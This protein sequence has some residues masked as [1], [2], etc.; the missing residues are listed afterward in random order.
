MAAT[1]DQ[2]RVVRNEGEHRY[3]LWAGE[4]LA[5]FA[6]FRNG[7]EWIKIFHAE[8]APAYEGHGLGNRLAAGALDDVRSQG[9]GVIP[10]C[11]FIAHFVNE[12]P[13]YADL[14]RE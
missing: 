8:V 10:A 2:V 6:S 3:E 13:E 1:D 12:H 7:P 4:E 14:V 5:G 9:I 11:P